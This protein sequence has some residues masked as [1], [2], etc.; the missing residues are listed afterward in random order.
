MEF[1]VTFNIVK[2]MGNKIKLEMDD[3]WESNYQ[4]QTIPLSLQK[5]YTFD[6]NLGKYRGPNFK[7]PPFYLHFL[8]ATSSVKSVCRPVSETLQAGP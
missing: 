1:S 3:G 2:V 5:K 8:T 7:I 4:V 6:L